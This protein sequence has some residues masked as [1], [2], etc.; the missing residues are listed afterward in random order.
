MYLAYPF[1]LIEPTAV[2]ERWGLLAFDGSDCVKLRRPAAL[3]AVDIAKTLQ[4]IVDVALRRDA[5][6]S[7]ERMRE[8][9]RQAREQNNE[10]VNVERIGAICGMVLKIIDGEYTVDQAIGRY[11]VGKSKLPRWVMERLRALAPASAEI[12]APRMEPRGR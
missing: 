12:P 10:R 11:L 4:V 6:T 5:F 7:Y 8:F 1:G 9:D 3:Q 2:D